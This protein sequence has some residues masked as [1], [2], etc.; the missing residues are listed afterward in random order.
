MCGIN[1]SAREAA[2]SFFLMA[3]R[4]GGGG[5]GQG[6]VKKKTFGYFKTFLPL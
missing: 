5:K 4:G 2:K 6:I 3:I 1:G